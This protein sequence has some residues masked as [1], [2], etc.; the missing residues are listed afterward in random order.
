M[1]TPTAPAGSI[2]SHALEV[3][4]GQRFEFGKNWS[5]FLKVLDEDRIERAV[6]SLRK[7]LGVEDLNGKTF[8]DIGSGSGLFS[9]SSSFILDA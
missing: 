8:L 1:Q 3:D 5:N 2:D 9:T 7:L 4:R 6:T